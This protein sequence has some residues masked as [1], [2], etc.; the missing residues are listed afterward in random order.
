MARPDVLQTIGFIGDGQLARMMVPHAKNLG[1]NVVVLGNPKP[2]DISPAAQVGA[3]QL[4]GE[5][6][7]A[8][9]IRQL[10]RRVRVTGYEIEHFNTEAAIENERAGY[11]F[12]PSSESVQLIQDKYKQKKFLHDRDI[13]VPRLYDIT[14]ET[15]I[16]DALDDS[17]EGIMLKKRHGAYDGRGNAVVRSHDDV[18]VVYE[19]KLG[20]F[21]VYAEELI[22]FKKEIAVIT[23]MDISGNID[24]YP[25]V[26]TVHKDNIC[27]EVTMKARISEKAERRALKLAQRV[28]L[29]FNLTGVSAHE[30]FLTEDDEIL[31]NESAPRVHNSGHLTDRA[32]YTSQF[33]QHVRIMAGFSMGRTDMMVE[34]AA[35]VNIL[36]TDPAQGVIQGVD[37]A[38]ML[39]DV[40]IQLYGKGGGVPERPRKRGHITALA[41]SP[42]EA[43]E[44]AREARLRIRA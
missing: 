10:S 8:R 18:R 31:H 26:E 1:L 32:S 38:L 42:E 22:R 15:E 21:D 5:L 9:A 39:P 41:S 28:A 43:L 25:V 34:G 17:P 14:S 33:E 11:R 30:M 29:E 40:F 23:S 3:I 2:G 13:P 6:N 7:D 12:L 19:E 35:M 27:H 44:K 36:G 16:H 20:G 37:A 24:V 4:R